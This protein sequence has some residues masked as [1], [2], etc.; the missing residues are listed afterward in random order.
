MN[1]FFYGIEDLFVH[2]LFAPYDGLRF[3]ESWWAANTVNWFFCIIGLV[4]AGYWMHQLK[5]FNDTGAE[6]KGITSHSYL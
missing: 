3:M 1:T 2:V 6:D 5:I 4:A